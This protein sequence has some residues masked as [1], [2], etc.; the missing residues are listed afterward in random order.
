MFPVAQMVKVRK[1]IEPVRT[2]QE[3]AKSPSLVLSDEFGKGVGRIITS[4]KTENCLP[5]IPLPIPK[6]SLGIQHAPSGRASGRSD[7]THEYFDSK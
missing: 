4:P 5:H 6:T 3:K 1:W 7:E 2:P